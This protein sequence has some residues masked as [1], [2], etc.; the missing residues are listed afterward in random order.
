MV[1]TT[2]GR[3]RFGGLLRHHDFRHLWVADAVSQFGT[4]VSGLAVPLLVVSVLHATTFEVTAVRTVQTAAY[5]LIGLQVGAWVDRM[6]RWPVLLVADLGRA[7][8]LG[9]V[10]V[11][12]AL[13]VLTLPQ[14][15]VSVFVTGVLTVFFDV[16]RQ[17]Y[18]PSLVERADLVEGNGKLRANMSVAAL[19]AS[20]VGGF[21]VQW[22]TAPFTVAVDAAG[23]LWSAGWLGTIRAREPRRPRDGRRRLAAEVAEGARLVFGQPILRAIGLCNATTA[24]AQSAQMSL[25]VVFLVRDVRLTPG[26]IGV[27]GTAGL[28]GALVGS[29]FGRRL[30]AWFGAARILWGGAIVTGIGFLL[31]PLTDPG[32][33]LGFYVLAGFL[34]SA[35]ITVESVVQV[36]F[37]QALCPERLRGRVAATMNVLYW[38]A[39]PIGSLLAG[40]LAGWAGP[41]VTLWVAGAGMLAASGWLLA[42]PLRTLRD[43]PDGARLGVPR[44]GYTR[45]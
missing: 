16:A 24:L 1:A 19:S 43:L 33:R 26:V 8:A 2:G 41:R 21:L 34:A 36:S 39:A 9:W 23:Y 35:A 12:A 7:V 3:R 40:F 15:Y 4:R 30:T 27:L 29:A 17:S 37:Q 32:W 28:V 14:V 31:Y 20:A 44:S 18:L 13:G 22:L 25:S 10:P 38:G 45:P 6:R 11:G 5:L 42:S